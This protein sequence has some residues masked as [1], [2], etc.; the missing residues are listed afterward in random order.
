MVKTQDDTPKFASVMFAGFT[1]AAIIVES[2]SDRTCWHSTNSYLEQH[3]LL[4]RLQ[5]Q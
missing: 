2:S 3:G 4:G 5:I 1:F